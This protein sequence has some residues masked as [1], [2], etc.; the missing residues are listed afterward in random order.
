M[1]LAAILSGGGGGVFREWNAPMM[2]MFENAI[3]IIGY[4]IEVDMGSPLFAVGC[5]TSQQIYENRSIA[6][7]Y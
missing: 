7:L 5:P 6:W 1:K 4:Y 2:T 3:G